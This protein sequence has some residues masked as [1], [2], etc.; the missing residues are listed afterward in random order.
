MFLSWFLFETKSDIRFSC[1]L[2]SSLLIY[3][4]RQSCKELI[5][6]Q[7]EDQ[8]F[9]FF[10]QI[11]ALF[12]SIFAEACKLRICCPSSKS[13]LSTDPS[14]WKSTSMML[15]ITH[16]LIMASNSWRWVADGTKN[17]H[18]YYFVRICMNEWS[19]AAEFKHKF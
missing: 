9:S 17:M 3:G 16:S 7:N 10:Q 8:F 4:T 2:R 15:L 13:R 14:D 11:Y 6:R 19:S 12:N 1:A 18:F 5:I